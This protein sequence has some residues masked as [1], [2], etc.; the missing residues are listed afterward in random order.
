MPHHAGN[1]RRKKQRKNLKHRMH[2][3][4]KA[5]RLAAAQKTQAAR[6]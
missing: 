2:K 5:A 3:R 6:S 4:T 1:T